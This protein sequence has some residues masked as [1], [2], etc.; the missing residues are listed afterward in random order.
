[1]SIQGDQ[2]RLVCVLVVRYY[3]LV[4]IHRGNPCPTSAVIVAITGWSMALV[5][6]DDAHHNHVVT[7][8]TKVVFVARLVA[9]PFAAYR[10]TEFA[11][12]Q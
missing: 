6:V 2:F 4:V 5:M 1:M 11:Q 12:Y 9:Y 7:L 3:S 8:R 10:R